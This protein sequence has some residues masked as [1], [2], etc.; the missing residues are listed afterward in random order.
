MKEAVVKPLAYKSLNGMS[1]KLLSEHHDVLYAGYVKKLN[2]IR[3]KLAD[4][5]LSE[6]N[7]T[8]SLFGEL[9]REET[10]AANGIRLH[11]AYFDGLGGNGEPSGAMQK[12]IERDCGSFE[13]WKAY[14]TAAGIAARGWVVAAYDW[15]TMSLVCYS[16]DAHNLGCV[17]NTSPLF[18]LDVY[19]H[20]YYLDYAT[21]RKGY[22]GA[23]LSNLNFDHAN[24]VIEA[25]GITV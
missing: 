20:A 10:F 25:A 11:E 13:N 16:C 24:G 23:W 19:E 1:E 21:A 8:Y 2:E 18:V 7:G 14:M 6:A 12:L 15:E 9:K 22:I 3:A 5:D 4:A 17:W